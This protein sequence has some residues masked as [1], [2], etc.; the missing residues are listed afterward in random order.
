MAAS[1]A[2]RETLQRL[3]ALAGCALPHA[4]FGR[5]A[6]KPGPLRANVD[7]RLIA[8]QPVPPGSI[9]AVEFF[10]YGCPY[11]FRFHPYFERWTRR[12]RADVAV[13][14]VPAVFRPSWVPHAR[15]YYT[16][17]SLDALA[18]LHGEV[19][20]SYHVERIALDSTDSIADWAQRHGLDREHWLS[21]YESDAV[22]ARVFDARDQ[23][24]R[25]EVTGTPSVVIDGRYLTSSGMTPGVAAMVPVLDGL[26]AL[27]RGQHTLR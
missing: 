16:L 12:Q 14:L 13:R 10:W 3:A 9:E 7:Y 15:L 21:V 25:Y 27:A 1:S 22:D 23:L 20:V 24:R 6:D 11:C 18:R 5:D 17:E 4:A 8:P 26:V 2:R 19:Y